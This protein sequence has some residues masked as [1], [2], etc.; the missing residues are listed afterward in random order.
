MTFAD[1]RAISH[2]DTKCENLIYNLT[3]D[4]DALRDER[5]QLK[6]HSSNLTKEMEVL[7]SQ[8]SAVAASRD[9]LQEMVKNLSRTGEK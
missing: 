4:K 1:A 2:R 3:K 5:D 8:Y 7:Q 9:E 6:I